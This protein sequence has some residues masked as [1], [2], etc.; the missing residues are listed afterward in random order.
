MQIYTSTINRLLWKQISFRISPLELIPCPLR[1]ELQFAQNHTRRS[2]LQCVDNV[3]VDKNL[4]FERGLC[5]ST[6][7]NPTKP[8][9]QWKIT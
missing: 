2:G 3:V 4:W 5:V 6:C 9:P 1:L 8:S 7:C